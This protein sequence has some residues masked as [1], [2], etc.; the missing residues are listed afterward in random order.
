MAI[1]PPGRTPT[2]CVY[3]RTSAAPLGAAFRPAD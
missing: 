3:K 1:A 2:V